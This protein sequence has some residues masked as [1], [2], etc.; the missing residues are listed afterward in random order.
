V[1]CKTMW[2][3]RIQPRY[4][5]IRRREQNEEDAITAIILETSRCPTSASCLR[6]EALCAS[7]TSSTAPPI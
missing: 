7:Y 4:T 6:V 2:Y 5:K 3:Y 1:Y